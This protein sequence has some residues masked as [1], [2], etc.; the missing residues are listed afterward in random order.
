MTDS[1]RLAAA[2]IA[3]AALASLGI[4]ASGRPAAPLASGPIVVVDLAR[5]LQDARPFVDEREGIRRWIEEQKRTNLGVKNDAIEAKEAELE[6]Y[7]PGSEP[8]R[9]LRNEIEF[10]KLGFQ[11]E[12]QFLESVRVRRIVEAQRRAYD[13]AREAIGEVASRHGARAALQL[14]PHELAAQ[15]EKGVSSE[16]F[17]RDVLW[18]DASLDI[19]PEVIRILDAPR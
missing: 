14:R 17:L 15:D 4:Q 16:I 2:V 10:A 18:H 1:L 9:K 3:V 7:E 13:R 6:L 8:Y 11:Q 19:T 12:F 5:V